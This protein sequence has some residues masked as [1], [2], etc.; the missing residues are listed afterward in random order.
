MWTSRFWKCALEELETPSQRRILR[1]SCRVFVFPPSV[2]LLLC[3]EEKGV[4]KE[5]NNKLFFFVKVLYF[6]RSN[7]KC[8]VHV[9][10]F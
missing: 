10:F 4:D 2:V 1:L 7:K 9:L 3:F 8:L 5:F 6:D